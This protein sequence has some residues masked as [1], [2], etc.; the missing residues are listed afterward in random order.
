MNYW[1]PPDTSMFPNSSN[2]E[3]GVEGSSSD[4]LVAIGPTKATTISPCT[5]SLP[6][7]LGVELPHCSVK[8]EIVLNRA[9]ERKEG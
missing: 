8:G 2:A 6:K 4:A 1:H 7:A 3:I 9:T 5:N